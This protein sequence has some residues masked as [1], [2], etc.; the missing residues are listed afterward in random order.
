[1]HASC[2]QKRLTFEE[3]RLD[4]LWLVPTLLGS[5]IRWLT[6]NVPV[7]RPDFYGLNKPNPLL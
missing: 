7:F 2:Y 1:V 5:S 4:H 6:V 3:A